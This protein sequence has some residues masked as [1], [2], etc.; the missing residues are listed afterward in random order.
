MD[1][2]RLWIIGSVLAMVALIALG[3]LLGIQPQLAATAI[4]IE[5]RVAVEQVNTAHEAS[6]AK[7][8]E[9]FT[10]IDALNDELV[11]LSRSV[12][13]GTDVPDYVDQLD[14]LAKANN[15]TLKGLT[16]AD[17]TAYTP[18]APVAPVAPPAASGSTPSPTP[19]P[20]ATSAPIDPVPA[21]GAPPVSNEA[22]TPQNFASLGVNIT[23]AGNYSDVLNF[24]NGLQTGSRLFLV[25]G[26]STKAEQ[27]AV[28]PETT[29]SAIDD[30]EAA[31]PT[32]PGGVEG[33]ISGLIY[34]LVASEASAEE[35][36]E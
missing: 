11:T 9:D 35:P 25:T 7:L 34:S 4:A 15:V 19:S 8:K 36:A 29:T 20:T 32:S 28:A 14:A 21:P 13:F 33:I 6:L 31:A 1:K 5:Q 3:W 12:P 24:V 27:Q 22:I 30:D 2:T 18:V 23:V 26:L 17:P 16:V 10:Q